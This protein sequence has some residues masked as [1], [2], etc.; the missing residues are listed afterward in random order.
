MPLGRFMLLGRGTN[1]VTACLPERTCPTWAFHA[2]KRPL[3]ASHG[4]L[5]VMLYSSLSGV[6]PPRASGRSKLCLRA[7]T[8]TDPLLL[9]S[10]RITTCGRSNEG[11]E[12][13]G[14]TFRCGSA[15]A[16]LCASLNEGC[17]GA[18][19]LATSSAAEPHEASALPSSRPVQHDQPMSAFLPHAEQACQ[20]HPTGVQACPGAPAWPQLLAHQGELSWRLSTALSTAALCPCLQVTGPGAAGPSLP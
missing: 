9:G 12:D 10:S 4:A 7:S 8:L 1:P 19:A 20:L 11:L 15:C 13:W 6:G 3:R 17:T 5:V 2:R 16:G 14:G 18:G